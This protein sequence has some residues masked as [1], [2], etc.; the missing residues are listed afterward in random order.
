MKTNAFLLL[1][2]FASIM[3]CTEEDSFKKT[4]PVQVDAH[5]KNHHRNYSTHLNGGQERPNPVETKAQGQAHFKLNK[6]GTSLHYKLNVANIENVS[7]AHL[8]LI[9]TPGGT[10][11]GV[12]VWLYPVSGPPAQLI[13]GRSN[14]TLAEGEITDASLVGALT[15]MT[16]DDLITAINEGTVYVNVHTTQ[17]PPGEI[18]GDI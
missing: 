6:E 14:G 5:A 2:L 7:Q 10:T 9:T 16:L 15:G 3:A 4:L 13:P 17:N 8:H 18:R 1:T 11:G 12:V